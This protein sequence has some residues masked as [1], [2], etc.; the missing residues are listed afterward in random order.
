MSRKKT[1]DWTVLDAKTGELVCLRCDKRHKIEL[2]QP[3]TAVAKLCGWWTELH[4]HCKPK[5]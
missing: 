3:I 4:R 5:P 1:V 2:P